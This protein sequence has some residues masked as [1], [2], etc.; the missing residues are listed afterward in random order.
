MLYDSRDWLLLVYDTGIGVSPA[1]SGYSFQV[2]NRS[3][4]QAKPRYTPVAEMLILVGRG[5]SLNIAR[6]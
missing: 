4:I 1:V 2:Y 5:F 3:D 6:S